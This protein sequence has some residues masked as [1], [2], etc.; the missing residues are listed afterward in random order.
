MR[1]LCAGWQ[2]LEQLLGAEIGGVACIRAHAENGLRGILQ[3]PGQRHDG[4]AGASK[5]VSDRNSADRVAREDEERIVALGHEAF[6]HLVLETQ[7][8]F[9]RNF[10]IGRTKPKILRGVSAGL[11]PGCK[12]RVRSARNE[13]DTGARVRNRRRGGNH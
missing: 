10:V 7:F 3:A 12:I 13:G 4:R 11:L 6:E 9:L 8:P 2:N 5:F 1:D